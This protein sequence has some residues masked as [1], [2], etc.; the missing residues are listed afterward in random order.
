MPM[1]NE[2]STNRFYLKHF[3][4]EQTYS[5]QKVP[6]FFKSLYKHNA[7]FITSKNAAN[8][9]QFSS[10]ALVLKIEKKKQKSGNTFYSENSVNNFLA[11]FSLCFYL[12]LIVLRNIVS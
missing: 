10:E 5:F 7:Q 1:E 8:E 9:H 6:H 12:S 2:V 3:L 4:L 11:D